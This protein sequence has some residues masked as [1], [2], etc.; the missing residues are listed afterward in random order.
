MP[1]ATVSSLSPRTQHTWAARQSTASA[2]SPHPS[3]NFDNGIIDDDLL[4][5]DDHQAR[6]FFWDRN[7]HASGSFVNTA[8]QPFLD[9]IKIFSKGSVRH[10]FSLKM[11]TQVILERL[12]NILLDKLLR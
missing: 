6:A 2:L 3:F 11:L 5:V 9:I 8:A 7:I 12:R 4:G 1:S 10:L